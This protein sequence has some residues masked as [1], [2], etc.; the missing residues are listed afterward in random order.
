MR[1]S[2][3]FVVMALLVFAGASVFFLIS[4]GTSPAGDCTPAD[5]ECLETLLSR[6][7]QDPFDSRL[8]VLRDAVS[9]APGQAEV[10]CGALAFRVGV[11]SRDPKTDIDAVLRPG[12]DVP[13]PDA[14][15]AGLLQSWRSAAPTP[16]DAGVILGRCSGADTTVC[17]EAVAHAAF[18]AV[19]GVESARSCYR[20]TGTG[21]V[22]CLGVLLSL[23]SEDAS[24]TDPEADPRDEVL[25][26]CTDPALAVPAEDCATAAGPVF[27]SSVYGALG[28]SSGPVDPAPVRDA[29][30]WC[31]RLGG[32]GL[33]CQQAAYPVAIEIGQVGAPASTRRESYCQAFDK[34][35]VDA[36]VS[37]I[38]GA[39]SPDTPG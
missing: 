18:S 12:S 16:E 36:C 31:M 24:V 29:V 8:E 22:A 4:R 30:S 33:A 7:A 15:V 32:S 13:C 38:A 28:F 37:L 34:S 20:L 10:V 3:L 27:L 26:L 23:V 11:E 1:L 21:P 25:A 39:A 14:L 35:L 19:D 6:S 17:A 9:L 5:I 2:R